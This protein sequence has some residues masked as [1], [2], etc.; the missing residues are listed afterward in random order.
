MEPNTRII[1][2]LEQLQIMSLF[3]DSNNYVLSK[4][5]IFSIPLFTNTPIK[6]PI[7]HLTILNNGV[8]SFRRYWRYPSKIPSLCASSPFWSSHMEDGWSKFGLPSRVIELGWSR[9]VFQW[10]ARAW[11]YT[12]TMITTNH[13]TKS[14]RCPYRQMHWGKLTFYNQPQ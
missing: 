3:G 9:S 1:Y 6:I 5:C 13:R 10:K 11:A 4:K 12:T 2:F 8:V 14:L 7:F